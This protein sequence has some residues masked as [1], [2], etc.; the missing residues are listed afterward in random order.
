MT[1]QK[2]FSGLVRPF[3][4]FLSVFRLVPSLAQSIFWGSPNSKR[5]SI[6]NLQSG[7]PLMMSKGADPTLVAR[8]TEWEKGRGTPPFRHLFAMS[9]YKVVGSKGLWRSP[10]GVSGW[11]VFP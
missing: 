4:Q 7:L 6:N 1:G 3:S 9:F 10:L 8:S 11:K 5:R 2:R